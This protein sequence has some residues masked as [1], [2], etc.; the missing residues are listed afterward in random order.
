MLALYMLIRLLVSMA[1]VLLR[2]RAVPGRL[3]ARRYDPEL[4]H[5]RLEGLQ[6]SIFDAE[7]TVQ[8]TATT[9]SSG[10][11]QTRGPVRERVATT[12]KSTSPR[13]TSPPSSTFRTRA[14]RTVAVQSMTTYSGL[15]GITTPRFQLITG[16]V[17]V[18]EQS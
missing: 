14:T 10:W 7:P 3:R 1:V 8:Q 17:E 13:A 4:P 18:S 15:R 11:P 2:V 5:P 6:C 12:P 16:D 9:I